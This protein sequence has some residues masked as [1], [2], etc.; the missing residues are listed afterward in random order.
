MCYYGDKSPVDS[1]QLVDDTLENGFNRWICWVIRDTA[2]GDRVNLSGFT[3]DW[4]VSLFLCPSSENFGKLS[5]CHIYDLITMP[6]FLHKIQH[7]VF[8]GGQ[9]ERMKLFIHS[10]H[11]T[12]NIML[13]FLKDYLT[14]FF[15][16]HIG[17]V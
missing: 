6:K 17:S 10:R 7:K 15:R 8:L 13:Q 12:V 5:L 14:M 3:F 11:S 4:A 1:A 9:I 16:V 2:F